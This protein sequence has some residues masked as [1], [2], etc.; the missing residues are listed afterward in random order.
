MSD[1]H[2]VAK[3]LAAVFTAH[4]MSGLSPIMYWSTPTTERY[5]ECVASSSLSPVIGS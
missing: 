1:W 5:T 3:D 2:G 4:W